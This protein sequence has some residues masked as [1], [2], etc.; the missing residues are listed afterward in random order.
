MT[1]ANEP[2]Q[3]FQATPAADGAE[4]RWLDD[5]EARV[6]R[7]YLLMSRLLG[8]QLGRGLSREVGMS[9][10]DFEVL[11]NLS[12]EP[13]RRL[14]MNELASRLLWEKSRLSHQ[15]T[16][17]QQRGLVKR[18]G[19]LSDARGSFVALT[20]A[21]LK[22]IQAAA[23]GHVRDVRRHFFDLLSDDDLKAL[24][25]ISDKVVAHLTGPDAEQA[26]S[27]DDGEDDCG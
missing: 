26:P 22:A 13:E 25:A 18:E 8:A 7:G 24:A 2:D 20:D 12:E 3:G 17:M 15:I 21:G 6:W 1:P 19:C 10:A 27:C 14:R 9:H 4:P 11:V 5:E 16:R 23:P